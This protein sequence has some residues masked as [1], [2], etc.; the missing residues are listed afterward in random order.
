MKTSETGC[1]E[2][3]PLTFRCACGWMKYAPR[4]KSWV[5]RRIGRTIGREMSCAIR[6]RAG[7][8]LVV[9]PLNL[10][11]YCQVQLHNGV[12][13][14]DVLDACLRVT[15]P[16]DIFFDI[17]AN[18]GIVTVDLARTFGENVAIHAFE[19]QPTLARTLASSIAL[20]EFTRVH[21]HRV[22]L[23]DTPGEADLYVADHAIHSSLVPR[24]AGATRLTCRMETIDRLVADG[25]LPAPT[26]IKLDVEGAEFRVLRGARQTFRAKPPVIVF[27]ADDNMARFG[28]THRDLF[29]LLREFA[30]YTFHR[31]SGA[32]WVPLNSLDEA[33]LG[34]YI[35]LPPSW[36]R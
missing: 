22:L 10:D 1:A 9:D 14:A 30:D 25:S 20:N 17:G 2:K 33:A 36:R 15:Q 27:E 34:D 26:V 13:E 16:G 24:E 35:A 29:G 18:A 28:Y 11:F 3:L 21:L 7:A 12:W 32:A 8:R 4:A 23:G 6:T 31:I 5:P 19:P